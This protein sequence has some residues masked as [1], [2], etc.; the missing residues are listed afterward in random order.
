MYDFSYHR[1]KSVADAGNLLG[2][3]EEPK[4]L[5]GG[6]SLVPNLKFRLT[7]FSNVVDLKGIDELRGITRD[8][9]T[10]TVGA[11]T[12]H[13]DVA[14]SAEVKIAIPALSEL[15]NGIGDPLVRNRGTIGGS[16]A[17]A[18]PA[19]DYP[20]AVL[21]L[22][23]TIVTNRREIAGDAFFQGLFETAL[24]PNEIITAV[25]F[26]IPQR[27]GYAKFPNPATRFAMVGVFVAQTATCARVA[28]T[29][30]GP[31]AFRLTEAEAALT[32]RFAPESLAGLIP[33]A[34]ALSSDIHASAE[35]RAHIITV[36]AKRAVMTAA[37]RSLD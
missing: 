32:A 7:Q 4:L 1:A 36:M 14:A 25:R 37:T 19:A 20:A 3:K 35:Y 26:P 15:A 6:M 34:T 21:G 16:I 27:A 18:D 17:N 30:A 12:R 8:G 23:A 5:A 22:R 10:L 11:M 2:V 29:G 28:V 13:A 24:E 31:C 9:D 33:D